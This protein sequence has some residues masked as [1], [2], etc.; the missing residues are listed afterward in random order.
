[1]NKAIQSNRMQS[2]ILR[3]VAIIVLARA[4]QYM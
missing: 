3:R 2:A 4:E 1:M